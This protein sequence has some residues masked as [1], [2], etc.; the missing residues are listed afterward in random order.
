MREE[1]QGSEINPRDRASRPWFHQC[2]LIDPVAFP[3]RL[4][5]A[6]Q[7]RSG[8]LFVMQLPCK[9]VKLFYISIMS[10]GGD[11]MGER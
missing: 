4:N 11:L 1:D 2:A 5:R 10:F 7:E 3:K 9:S 8:A 6:F